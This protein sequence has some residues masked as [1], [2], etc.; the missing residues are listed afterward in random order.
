VTASTPETFPPAEEPIH[1]GKPPVTE[2]VLSVQFTGD[3]IDLEVLGR[4]ASRV[5]TDFPARQ[6]QPPLPKMTAEQSYPGYNEIR[7]EF[8]QHLDALLADVQEVAPS[9]AD[10]DFCELI[11]VNQLAQ[12]GTPA[13]GPHPPL[14]RFIRFLQPFSGEE[15]LPEAEDSRLQARWRI[16]SGGDEPRGRLYMAAEP[17]YR[18]PGDLPMYLLT[19]T[20]RLV[21]EHMDLT[22]AVA[23]LD[24]GH[25]W[26]AR[27]FR[28]LTTD[29]MHHAWEMEVDD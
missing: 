20:A 10:I 9:A 17:G 14:S 27:G 6:Q 24:E 7:R 22:G 13:K 11:Y 25:N 12:E 16:Q 8:I 19:L 15:F 21:G 2:V 1:F 18:Q 29:E 4:V 26:A 28:D 23:L 5:K 3:A